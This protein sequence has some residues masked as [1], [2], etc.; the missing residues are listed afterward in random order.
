ME[1]VIQGGKDAPELIVTEEYGD[2]TAP[3]RVEGSG[4]A[5]GVVVER[6]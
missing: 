4:D 3:V 2:V 1:V 5:A 6:G